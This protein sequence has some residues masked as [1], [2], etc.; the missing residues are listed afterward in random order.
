[1]IDPFHVPDVI[2]P[3]VVSED[4]PDVGDAPI[5]LYETVTADEPL[6]VDPLVAPLPP[7]LNVNELAT[8]VEVAATW[9]QPE[10]VQVYHKLG[11]TR[12]S[13][14]ISP[15]QPLVPIDDTESAG[16]DPIGIIS[17][18]ETIELLYGLPAH[19][20]AAVAAIDV[21]FPTPT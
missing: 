10:V 7:L 17:V 5:V 19:T 11:I 14:T 16:V 8:A 20:D 6:N 3:N 13:H 9:V 18:P 12:R 21:L 15:A 4:D 2:V 1:M